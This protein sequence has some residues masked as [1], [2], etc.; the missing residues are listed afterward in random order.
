MES[1]SSGI[2]AEDIKAFAKNTSSVKKRGVSE[3]T[4]ENRVACL[5]CRFGHWPTNKI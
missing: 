2:T 1:V 3:G 4:A 5:Q